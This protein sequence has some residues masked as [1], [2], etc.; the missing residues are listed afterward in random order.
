ME[1]E[2][3]RFN[4]LTLVLYILVDVLKLKGRI[5][6]VRMA[7]LT[8]LLQDD[9]IVELLEEEDSLSFANI[10]VLNKSLL[11]SIN[12]RFYHTLPLLVNASSILMD[13]G[14]MTI[15][16][17][18][19]IIINE[20]GKLAFNKLSGVD[21]FTARRIDKVLPKM[22]SICDLVTTKRMIKDLNIEI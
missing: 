18:D 11:A 13:A 2:R 21:S 19:M 16:E 5:D 15:Q 17:G 8:S 4:Y 20:T 10:R 14:F 3:V 6:M 22:I 7:V 9:S 1:L 12:R